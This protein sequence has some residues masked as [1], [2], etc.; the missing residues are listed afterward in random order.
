MF[1]I[2]VNFCCFLA[3]GLCYAQGDPH[4][5]T[6]DGLYYDYQGDCTLILVE[7]CVDDVD[8]D[9]YFRVLVDN[10]KW[11]TNSA[12]AI[13]VEVIVEVYGVVSC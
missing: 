5:R 13:T 10:W 6:F 9:E 7:N 12:V 3:V 1:F 11:N 4:Y 8:D 2:S